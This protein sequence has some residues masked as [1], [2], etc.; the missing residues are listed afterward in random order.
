[1]EI[2]K[3]VEG[4][5][6]IYQVSS[7]GRIRSVD[8]ICPTKKVTGR[9]LKTRVSR[10]YLMITL[11]RLIGKKEYIRKWFKLHRLVAKSF[12]PNPNN[13]PQVN[14]INGIKDDNRVVNLEWCSPS[15]NA[16]HA[17][18]N[19]LMGGEKINTAKLTV[20]QVREIRH[21]LDNKVLGPVSIARKFNVS[22]T[23]IHA[24]SRRIIWKYV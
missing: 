3:S 21:L 22:Y 5:D 4:Y 17:V 14:H 12:L 10:G 13:L 18:R 23:T 16:I 15:E 7:E 19:G 20:D 1:M 6:G 9:I 11:D 8:R 24:I 2:W